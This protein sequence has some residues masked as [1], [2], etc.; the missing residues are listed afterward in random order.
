MVVELQIIKCPIQIMGDLIG[1]KIY[2]VQ[3]TLSESID[4][5]LNDICKSK[6]MCKIK[7]QKLKKND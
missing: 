1:H 4:I 7:P 6:T 5:F 3:R 2:E